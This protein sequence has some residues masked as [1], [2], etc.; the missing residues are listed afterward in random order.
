VPQRG[1]RSQPRIST[2]GIIHQKAARPE[3]A[4]HRRA[5]FENTRSAGLEVLKRRQIESPNKADAEYWR[6]ELLSSRMDG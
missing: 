6:L 4:P 5:L 1:Y 3:E 2:P